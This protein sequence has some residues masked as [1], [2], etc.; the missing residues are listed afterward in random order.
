M[1]AVGDSEGTVYILQLCPALYETSQKEKE[2]MG[3]IF[4]REFRREKNL[5][6]SKKLGKDVGAKA[7]DASK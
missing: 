4:D 1:A 2:V 3:Q 6:T 7:K 5:I